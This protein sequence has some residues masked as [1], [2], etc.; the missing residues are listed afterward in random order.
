MSAKT[1]TAKLAALGSKQLEINSE[2][3][4]LVS[5]DKVAKNLAEQHPTLDKEDFE[6]LELTMLQRA[7]EL[8]EASSAPAKRKESLKRKREEQKLLK[9]KL[10]N[11]AALWE[12]AV[13]DFVFGGAEGIGNFFDT[14]DESDIAEVVG[15][16]SKK[17][18]PSTH[19]LELEMG[20]DVKAD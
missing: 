19:E 8:A 5:M 3:A 12:Q 15:P 7:S 9:E 1:L 11:K 18:K 17:T 20:D 16:R 2:K 13:R 10:E 14:L 4:K 6:S